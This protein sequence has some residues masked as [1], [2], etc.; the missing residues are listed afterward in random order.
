MFGKSIQKIPEPSFYYAILAATCFRRKA[1]SRHR[2]ADGA[3]PGIGCRYLA[4]AD[5][6]RRTNA[7]ASWRQPWTVD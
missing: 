1:R 3:L 4:K 7:K 6:G 5:C 2:N